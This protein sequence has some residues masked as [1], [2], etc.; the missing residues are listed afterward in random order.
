MQRDSSLL[1]HSY[2]N[3]G[4]IYLEP[5]RQQMLL[6]FTS[7]TSWIAH[8]GQQCGLQI[9]ALIFETFTLEAV[10]PAIYIKKSKLQHNKTK[11]KP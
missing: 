1:D 10:K 6:E 3:S 4:I 9:T 7:E 8:S 2:R 5:T 11:K